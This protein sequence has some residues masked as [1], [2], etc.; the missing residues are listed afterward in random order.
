MISKKG[1]KVVKGK[2]ERWNALS[3]IQTENG[4]SLLIR[5]RMEVGLRYEK[6]DNL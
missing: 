5:M 1:R 3:V 4:K 2:K 6:E